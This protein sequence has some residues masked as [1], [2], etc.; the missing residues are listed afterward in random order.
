MFSQSTYTKRLIPSLVTEETP[1]PN[2]DGSG[3]GGTQTGRRSHKSVSGN[4]ANE[5]AFSEFALLLI[6][7][8]PISVCYCYCPILLENIFSTEKFI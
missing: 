8:Y 2:S 6:P 3:G 7:P 5:Q 4:L 1:L